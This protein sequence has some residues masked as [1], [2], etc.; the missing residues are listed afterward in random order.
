VDSQN[1]GIKGFW[2][3]SDRARSS[4]VFFIRDDAVSRFKASTGMG[5]VALI[6]N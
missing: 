6:I 3:P 5:A 2:V 1:E 4:Y